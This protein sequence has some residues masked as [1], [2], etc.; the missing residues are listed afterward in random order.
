MT[1]LCCLC[2]VCFVGL[3]WIPDNSRLSPAENLKSEHINTL[4][5]IV[6]FT[7]PCQTRLFYRVLCGG[8]NWVAP[9]ARQVSSVSGGA[10]QLPGCTP[11]QNA[12]VQR[13][14]HTTRQDKTVA[15]ASRPLLPQRRPG[16][17]LCLATRLPTQ[18]RCTPR[19]C[20]YTVD[21]CMWL[22]LNLFT[23]HRVTRAIYRLTVQTLSDGLETIHTTWHDHLVLWRAVWIGHEFSFADW[24]STKTRRHSGMSQWPNNVGIL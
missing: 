8:V 12:F 15:P 21:C 1:K 23:K 11:M 10:V 17:Q 5:T 13:S 16:R 14:I 19:K 20:K 24:H 22:N 7:P 6:Q 18:R 2:L 4:I 3:N 9:S